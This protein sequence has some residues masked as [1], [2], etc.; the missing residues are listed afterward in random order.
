MANKQLRISRSD[1]I[2]IAGLPGTGKTTLAKYIGSLCVPR[3][4]VYDPLA[5]Y[6][7][8]ED[9]HRYIPKGDTA[10]EF[11]IVCKRLMAR[12][13][14]M[15]VVEECERYIGQGRPLGDDAFDVINRGR[16]FG[17]GITAVTRRI[18]RLSKDYF[19]L[20]QHIIFFKCGLK[21]REYISD[22]I[23]WADTNKIRKLSKYSFL[24]Y[25]VESEESSIHTL[26]MGT[27]TTPDAV[28]RD[29]KV[30]KSIAGGKIVDG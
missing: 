17:I 28:A 19:D 30:E 8:F 23:G 11:N 14:V 5:Q 2:T 27:V 10:A 29:V 24:Y 21:S 16:N 6:N 9:E 3:V 25:N 4:L 7:G 18:Q 20:C 13:N 15:F 26:N 1:R 12:G 22:M